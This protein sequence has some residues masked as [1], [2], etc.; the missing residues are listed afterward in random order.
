MS[1]VSISRN[2]P[3]KI[4]NIQ[5]VFRTLNTELRIFVNAGFLLNSLF[6]TE[7]FIYQFTP[8]N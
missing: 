2:L 6:N 7:Q 5:T 3:Q 8:A 1:S 4:E